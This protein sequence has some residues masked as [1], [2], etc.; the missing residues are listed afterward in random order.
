MMRNLAWGVLLASTSF[1]SFWVVRSDFYP[2]SRFGLTLVVLFFS[3]HPLGAFWMILEVVRS[4]R[5]RWKYG[6]ISLVPYAFAWYY[7]ERYARRGASKVSA[8]GVS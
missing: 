6:L 5:Q 2:Q 8:K 4:E 1:F 7:F 3:A